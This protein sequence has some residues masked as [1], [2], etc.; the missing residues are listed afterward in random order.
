MPLPLLAPLAGPLLLQP[1]AQLL[2]SPAA[3][4]AALLA[5][6]CSWRQRSLLHLLGFKLGVATWQQDWSSSWRPAP[7]LGSGVR[8]AGT[9]GTASGGERPAAVAAGGAA[10]GPGAAGAEVGGSAGAA[11]DAVGALL[12]QLQQQAAGAPAAGADSAAEQSA[13]AVTELAERPPLSAGAAGGPAAQLVAAGGIERCSAIV[14]AIRREEFG[15]GVELDGAGGWV[16]GWRWGWWW[17]AGH[18]AWP[19]W[20]VPDQ[21]LVCCFL[22]RLLP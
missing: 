17:A 11:G 8:S 1:A 18:L 3:M 2:G 5:A 7:A 12:Q 22:P 9:A 14:E 10:S 21:A 19:G 6:A 4:Q 15:L 16:G 20:C 13:T